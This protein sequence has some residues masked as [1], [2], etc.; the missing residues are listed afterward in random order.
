MAVPPAGAA[1]SLP[2]ANSSA[3]ALN[4]GQPDQGPL[5]P[6]PKTLPCTDTPY[7]ESGVS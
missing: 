7:N 1:P 5:T 2:T 4:C 6:A 3:R